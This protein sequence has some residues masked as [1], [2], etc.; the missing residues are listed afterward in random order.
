[1]ALSAI[2]FRNIGEAEIAGF[3]DNGGILTR[4]KIEG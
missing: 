4:E 2:R 1:M 3:G